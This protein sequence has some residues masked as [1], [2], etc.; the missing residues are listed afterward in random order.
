MYNR[1]TIRCE[2]WARVVSV[3]AEELNR[4]KVIYIP[5]FAHGTG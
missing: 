4:I 2:Y 1:R 5:W 3:I